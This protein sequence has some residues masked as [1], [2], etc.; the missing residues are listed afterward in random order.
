MT[1]LITVN[2]GD[3]VAGPITPDWGQAAADWAKNLKSD[4]T[5]RAY[6]EAWADFLGFVELPPDQVGQ[7][8]VIEYRS[9]LKTAVSEKTGRPF[10]QSTINQKLSAISAFYTFAQGRGLRADNPV[11]GVAR[12]AV[13]P[14]G[15]ASWLDVEAG[16]DLRLLAAI[17]GSTAQGLRDRAIIL[18]FLT[19]GLR[20]ES[21]AR[22][23]A[24][25]LRRQGDVAFL[26]VNVKRGKTFDKRLPTETAKA[27][28]AYLKTRSGDL[29][30]ASPLFTATERGRAAARRLAAVKGFDVGDED[31]LTARQIANLVKTYCNKAFGPGHGIHPHSLRHTAAKAAEVEGFAVTDISDL[32]GH[33]SINTTVIYMHATARAGDKVADRLGRRYADC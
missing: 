32:L 33:G 26:T 13:S 14:Y 31:P 30:P 16:D 8:D 25:D 24:G 23:K 19:L 20:V 21:V 3:L 10:S 9:H 4:R 22:L 18:V 2:R 6:L 12:E 27:I 11:E 28:D 17:D 1:E 7:S 15:R 5:R 29:A